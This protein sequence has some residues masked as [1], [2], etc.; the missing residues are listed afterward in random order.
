MT[1]DEITS[2]LKSPDLPPEAALAAGLAKA[3]ELAPGIY[4]SFAAASICSLR[5]TNS[6]SMACTSLQRQSIRPCSTI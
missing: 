1:L 6:F 4:S 2:A 3:D 5:K